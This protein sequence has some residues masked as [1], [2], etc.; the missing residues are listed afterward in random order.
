MTGLF[1]NRRDGRTLVWALNGMRENGQLHGRRSALT[2]QE[3]T[4]IDL[5]LAAF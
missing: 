3:E 5:G 4:L 2:P 1:W